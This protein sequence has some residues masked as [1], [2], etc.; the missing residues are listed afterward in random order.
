MSPKGGT[1]LRPSFER[2]YKES[3][4][5]KKMRRLFLSGALCGVMITAVFTFVF[6][7]PANSD[8]W[9]WEIWRRG[10]GAWTIDM[11][12][13]HRG[14]KWTVEPL[15]DAPPKKPVIVPSSQTKV[16]TEQL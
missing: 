16:S 5:N 1:G 9:R 4:G 3:V 7:I 8:H 6:A 14:W 15:P 11:K 12:S 2:L 13:G 10:G